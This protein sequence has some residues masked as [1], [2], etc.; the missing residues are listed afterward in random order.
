MDGVVAEGVTVDY[1]ITF[2][3]QMRWSP[4]SHDGKAENKSN[5]ETLPNLIIGLAR[6]R[7]HGHNKGDINS[8]NDA[9]NPKRLLPTPAIHKPQ[10]Y[11][12]GD[13][14]HHPITTSQQRNLMS[15]NSQSV[16]KICLIVIDDIDA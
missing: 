6:R 9:R 5:H 12:V 16:V 7:S 4:N 11:H 14:P 13:R 1:R 8:H 3:S 10:T 15:C 2:R